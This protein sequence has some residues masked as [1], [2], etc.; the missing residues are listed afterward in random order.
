MFTFFDKASPKTLLGRY[1]L[2]SMAISL[3]LMVC[4]MITVFSDLTKPS[5]LSEELKNY[6]ELDHDSPV[7]ENLQ[8]G[9][10]AYE[11][12]VIFDIIT[13]LSTIIAATCYI[14]CAKPDILST[15]EIVEVHDPKDQ[16]KQI[17]SGCNLLLK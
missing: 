17:D 11:L 4:M 10:R 12:L 15:L 1:A 6:L 14:K 5:E 7:L 16:R 2:S 13:V 9:I 8:Y 3:V